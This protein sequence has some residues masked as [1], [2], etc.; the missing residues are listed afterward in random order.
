MEG[1]HNGLMFS[2]RVVDLCD[3]KGMFCGR[4]LADLGADVIK[5]EKPGGDPSRNLG[6]FYCN[7]SD[8]Q[9][10]LFWLAFPLLLLY[11]PISINDL[12]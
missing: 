4:I 3:E 2:Y 10:S 11:S 8:Q 6:P 1:K 12:C 5:V 7:A 9:K